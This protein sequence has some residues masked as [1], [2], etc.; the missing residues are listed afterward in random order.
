MKHFK[1]TALLVL[2]TA[3]LGSVYAQPAVTGTVSDP[4][5]VTSINDLVWFS[6]Q[7]SLWG[8]G[9]YFIQMN[10]IDA[11][12]AAFTSTGSAAHPAVVNYDG[13]G[14]YINNLTINSDQPMSGLFGYLESG[15]VQNLKFYKAAIN[16]TSVTDAFAGVL[17]GKTG[18]SIFNCH[19]YESTVNTTGDYVGGLVGSTTGSIQQCYVW[20]YSTGRNYVGGIAGILDGGN[21]FLSY[22]AG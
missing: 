19:I 20:T 3:A 22:P 7:T 9:K 5:R 15:S 18:A 4:Y 12:D 6:T 14:F 11:K 1:L 10:D 16:N 2:L 13:Q 21:I 17:A 8:E